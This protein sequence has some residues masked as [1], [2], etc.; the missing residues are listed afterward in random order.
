MLKT[1]PPTLKRLSLLER[2]RMQVFEKQ[3]NRVLDGCFILS[4]L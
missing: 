3:I 4:L 2:S 1:R